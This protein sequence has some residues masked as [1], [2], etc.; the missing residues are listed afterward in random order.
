M[1]WQLHVVCHG[2]ILSGVQGKAARTEPV[3]SSRAAASAAS[4]CADMNL[5]VDEGIPC[6]G[7]WL[8]E[9]VAEQELMCIDEDAD[10]WSSELWWVGSQQLK[11]MWAV[12]ACPLS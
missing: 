1:R 2:S 9:Q 10:Q 5:A 11:C 8:E 7:K 6:M 4:G 12:D 3:P